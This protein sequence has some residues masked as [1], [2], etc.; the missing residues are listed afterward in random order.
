MRARIRVIP[1]SMHY[2]YD[3][4][5]TLRT[6][7]KIFGLAGVR[8][9]FGFAHEE[10]IGNLLKVK[11]PFEPS[12]PAEAA[13]IGALADREF[14]YRSLEQNVRG[15]RLFTDSLRELG[16]EFAPPEANFVMIILPDADVA[17]RLVHDLL[18]QGVIIRPLEAFGLPHCV[19]ISTGSDA[20]NETCVE[21]LRRSVLSAGLLAGKGV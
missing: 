8:V 17:A 19:R 12:A 3:N 5:I 18:I 21:A 10:L 9:G 20:D 2:R 15:I 16:L 11:L 14:Y 6:F 4:V 7:S 13:A 1:D